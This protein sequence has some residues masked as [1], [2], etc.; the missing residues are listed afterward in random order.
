[1]FYVFVRKKAITLLDDS[2]IYFGFFFDGWQSGIHFLW[3]RSTE[4][5]FSNLF[6]FL[7]RTDVREVLKQNRNIIIKSFKT[8][9]QV[10]NF[11]WLCSVSMAFFGRFGFAIF[12]S[13]LFSEYY[14]SSVSLQ[15]SS[16]FSCNRKTCLSFFAVKCSCSCVW[17]H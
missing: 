7:H 16:N 8:I 15:Q 17:F 13:K 12:Y 5:R 1:M 10:Q 14:R 11:H 6:P 2:K 3:L 9:F 4:I